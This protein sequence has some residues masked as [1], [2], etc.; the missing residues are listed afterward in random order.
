ME[1][2]TF[3]PSVDWKIQ[4]I[5]FF[6]K[7]YPNVSSLHLIPFPTPSHIHQIIGE[8]V[9]GEVVEIGPGVTRFHKGQCVMG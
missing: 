6:V 8:A 1:I 7:S 2:L 5:G 4:T 3:C 9:A